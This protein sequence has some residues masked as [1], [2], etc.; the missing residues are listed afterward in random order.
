MTKLIK[1]K[2][3]LKNIL[4]SKLEQ[5]INIVGK[6]IEEQLKKKYYRACL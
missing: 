4:S 3:E 2:S 5:V 6:Q 1:T